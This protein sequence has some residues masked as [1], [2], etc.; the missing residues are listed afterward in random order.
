MHVSEDICTHCRC[1]NSAQYDIA[2]YSKSKGEKTTEIGERDRERERD[3]ETESRE[4]KEA[5]EGSEGGRG[6]SREAGRGQR[7]IA[8]CTCANAGMH[9]RSANSL[10]R[11]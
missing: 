3:R 4:R 11:R 8:L 6:A 7:S 10:G 9:A 2:F 1:E 5:G